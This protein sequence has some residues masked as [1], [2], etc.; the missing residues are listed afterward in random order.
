ML[1]HQNVKQATCMVY[2]SVAYLIRRLFYPLSIRTHN[3]HGIRTTLQLLTSSNRL[4]KHGAGLSN[5][6]H[7]NTPPG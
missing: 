6:R 2:I 5:T 4:R 7:D 3:R 1:Y